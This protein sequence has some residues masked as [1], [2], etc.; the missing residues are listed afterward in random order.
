[1]LTVAIKCLSSP[2]RQGAR[3]SQTSHRLTVPGR[4]LISSGWSHNRFL[5]RRKL[6]CVYLFIICI[7]YLNT[8]LAYQNQIALSL[9][10]RK[11]KQ[12][13]QVLTVAP[14]YLSSPGRQGARTAQ[15]SHRLTVQTRH[16]RPSSGWSRNRF[17]TKRK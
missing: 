4:H 6:K 14:K 16:P 2:G 17:V 13:W 9:H 10:M 5:T 11:Y 7:Q 3:T 8:Y 15:V 1:M 12:Q